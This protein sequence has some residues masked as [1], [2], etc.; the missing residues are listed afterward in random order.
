M[1]QPSLVG[2]NQLTSYNYVA[3]VPHHKGTASEAS[4]ADCLYDCIQVCSFLFVS[5]PG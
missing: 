1:I 2:Q 3:Q 5:I 4:L